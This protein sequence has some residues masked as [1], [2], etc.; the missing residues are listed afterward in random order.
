MVSAARKP[1]KFLPLPVDF[2]PVV[3]TVDEACSYARQSRWTTFQKIRQGRYRTFLDGRI[4]KIEFASVVEDME[5]LRAGAHQG[6]VAAPPPSEPAVVK[7]PTGRPRKKPK[8][9]TATASAG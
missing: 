8:P 2:N 4:R 3:I 1:Y 9:E 5:R 7:R 6:P